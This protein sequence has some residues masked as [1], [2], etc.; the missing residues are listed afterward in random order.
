MYRAAYLKEFK[1][2]IKKYFEQGA[3]TLTKKMGAP[4]MLESLQE[5]HPR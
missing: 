3:A 1:A 4:E 5:D 2:E